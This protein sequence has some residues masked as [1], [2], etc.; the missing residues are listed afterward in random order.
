MIAW[1]LYAEQRMNATLLAEELGVAV[2]PKVLPT[3]K[4]VDRT[5]ITSMVRQ[6]MEAERDG[7]GDNPIKKMAEGVRFT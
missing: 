4:V 3:K 5:E 7:K 6:V 2:R 1:P